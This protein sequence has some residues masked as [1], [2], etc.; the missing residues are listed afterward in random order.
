MWVMSGEMTHGWWV[1]SIRMWSALGVSTMDKQ[2]W[3]M[4]DE[5]RVSECD[6]PWVTNDGQ[7]EMTHGWWVESIRMW[8]ALGYQ[9]W[10]NRDDPWV[11]SGEYQNVISPGLSTMDKQRWPMG[12]EWRVS[13]CDQPWVTTTNRMTHG[14]WVESIRMWSDRWTWV[15]SG[16]YQNVI[17]P[18]ISTMDKQRWPMGDEWRVS[19]CDQPWVTND[20]QTEMT[21]GWWVESIRMWS[22]LGVSTMD[23][24]RWPMGDEWRVSECD[25]P[26]VINDGQTE[27]T[28]GWWVESIRMWSALGVSTMDKQRWPMGDEWRVSECD[29]PWV[30]QMDKQR[31][32][33]GD[34]WRVSE[35]DEPWDIN[36]DKQRW[37]MGDEWRVSECD[38]PWVTNDG[39]TEMTHG[40]WVESI[41]MWSALGYQRWTNRDDPWV[42]SGEYQNVISPGLSTMDKQRW[43]MGDEW[44]VSECDQ[45]WV[46]TMDKQRWPMMMSG[47]Y[48]MWWVESMGDEWRVSECDQ[49]WVTTMES[50]RTWSD[51]MGDEWRVSE[52]DQPWVINECDQPWVTTMDKQR[53]PMGDE[54][55]VSECD[56]PWVTTMDKQRWPMGDEWRVSECDQQPL[57][58]V[59]SIRMWSDTKWT[60]RDDPWVMSGEYQNVISPGISTMDKQRWPM[61]DEWRVSECDQPWV[62][63]DKLNVMSGEYQNVIRPWVMDKQSGRVSECDQPWVTTMDKQKWPMGDEWRVSECD[64]PWVTNDGQTEM[65]H[66]WWVESIRMWS[67]LG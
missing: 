30:T 35:C 12:D 50:I 58:G 7:T 65:T 34:E 24:Q 22:A 45:P 16:E 60:N 56:Q 20:G 64:Q 49:P 59:E 66:G 63:N 6:Q 1:E 10:T 19:E 4:G 15:M 5:W 33:M 23:K 18:G 27:M 44:R 41:R 53:W 48:G 37:P 61:G 38:Q 36:D 17:S 26:W 11:M 2:R 29:Q 9:R 8:S 57:N 21:H 47:Q 46:I 32:P 51:H 25:Q 40:W 42:M 31:W 62:I 13:E 14:W 39:Q 55:R 28:H 67:A 52:C 43:P 54:W 3:P